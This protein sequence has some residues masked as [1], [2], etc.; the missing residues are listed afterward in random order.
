MLMM[1]APGERFGGSK[2]V[3]SGVVGRFPRRFRVG[4]RFGGEEG[5]LSSRLDHLSHL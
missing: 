2:N 4:A 3:L 5:F 1:E